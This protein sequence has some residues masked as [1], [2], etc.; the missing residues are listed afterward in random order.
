MMMVYQLHYIRNHLCGERVYG[1]MIVYSSTHESVQQEGVVLCAF[2]VCSNP[3]WKGERERDSL[4]ERIC[5]LAY[6]SLLCYKI[7]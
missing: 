5:I 6:N 3:Q 1:G 4:F 2:V 7:Q